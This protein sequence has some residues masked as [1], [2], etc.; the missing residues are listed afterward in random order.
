MLKVR[1]FL[2]HYQAFVSACLVGGAFFI[3]SDPDPSHYFV[4]YLHL[5]SPLFFLL[6]FIR[7]VSLD[8]SLPKATIH[9]T[10]SKASCLTVG[11]VSTEGEA[12]N[13]PQSKANY[14][15]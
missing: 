11:Q 8:I 12:E 13:Q 10:V 3:P 6:F 2:S 4:F 5:L 14:P 7:L 15:A 9:Y 1:L